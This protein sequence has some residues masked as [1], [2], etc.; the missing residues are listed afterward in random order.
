MK[1]ILMNITE[2]SDSREV[3]ES[4]PNP[5]FA[6][7]ILFLGIIVVALIWSYFVG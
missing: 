4:K 1:P 7:F 3:Y 2:L 5:I 6:I